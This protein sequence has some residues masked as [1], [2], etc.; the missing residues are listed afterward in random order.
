LGLFYLQNNFFKNLQI[1]TTFLNP[2]TDPDTERKPNFL[3]G[4]DPD[5]DRLQKLNPDGL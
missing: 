1:P 5:P 3:H 2:E 4:T